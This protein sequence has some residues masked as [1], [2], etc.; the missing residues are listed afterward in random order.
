MEKEQLDFYKKWFKDYVAGFYADDEYV[1]A[2]LKLKENHTY[3]VCSQ[4]AYLT[5]KLNIG[6]K[7]L[8]IAQTIALFHDVGRFEQFAKYGT[9]NDLKSVN[10][11][12]LALDVLRRHGVLNELQEG[13]SRVIK[14]A[15]RLHG[16]KSLPVDLD[17]DAE[18]FA[19]LIRDADKID[20]YR[21]VI[22]AYKQS[23][24][25]PDRLKLEIEFPD[26][27]N[28][29]WHVVEAVL[30]QQSLDY[31]QL[32]TL[33]DMKLMQLAWVFDVNFDETL[34]KIRQNQFLEQIIALLPQT[35][36]IT[37]V[38]KCVFDY[39]AARLEKVG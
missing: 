18:I 9:Y 22:E 16:Q 10:H 28:Y 13:Q 34:L 8:L 33:N 7:D 19:K 4:M 35:D 11:C 5:D 20:I 23:L 24:V 37:R 15:I 1:N 6:D 25:E 31:S 12:Q 26:E 2:N 38:A 3:A 14:T 17:R 39:V 30:R 27:P 29:S 36:D 32:R 21:V